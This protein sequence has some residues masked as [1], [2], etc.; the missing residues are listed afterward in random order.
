MNAATRKKL[1][2]ALIGPGRDKLAIEVTNI[3]LDTLT[4]VIDELLRD[5]DEELQ[6][7]MI[8]G[9]PT[10]C[11]ELAPI[12]EQSSDSFVG[13]LAG[14]IGFVVDAKK[15]KYQ[16]M[17]CESEKQFVRRLVDHI[18]KIFLPCGDECSRPSAEDV[19]RQLLQLADGKEPPVRAVML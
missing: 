6:K 17:A 12:G 11:L 1:F 18:K 16:C 9:H 3:D 4:P 13:E 2:D 14:G 7:P 10:A 19:E 15:A 8:C 5:R